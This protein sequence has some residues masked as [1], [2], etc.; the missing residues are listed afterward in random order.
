ME[1]WRPTPE[2]IAYYT[3]QLGALWFLLHWSFP[4]HIKRT[5]K[6]RVQDRCQQCGQ[7][8]PHSHKPEDQ[9]KVLQLHHVCFEGVAKEL[10]IP[11]TLYNHPA[12][13]LPVCNNC[14]KR[15]HRGMHDLS[16][17]QKKQMVAGLLRAVVAYHADERSEGDRRLWNASQEK[18][19]A[20][21]AQHAARLEIKL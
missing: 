8:I 19:L 15:I 18:I 7:H 5:T 9:T 6:E 4:D 14:H 11:D 20:L 1:R 12:N 21:V 10:E 13:A 17:S 3:F 16:Y 2:K